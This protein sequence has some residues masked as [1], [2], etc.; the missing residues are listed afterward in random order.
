[1]SQKRA[2]TSVFGHFDLMDLFCEDVWVCGKRCMVSPRRAEGAVAMLGA[3]QA[4]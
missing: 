4:E 3:L 2:R 1:V